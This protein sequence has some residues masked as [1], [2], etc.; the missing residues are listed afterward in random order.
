M[1]GSMH[2][3]DLGNATGG[4][5]QGTPPGTLMVALRLGMTIALKCGLFGH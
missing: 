1:R 3:A 5:A 4:G 2:P